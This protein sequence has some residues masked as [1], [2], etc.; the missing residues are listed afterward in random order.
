MHSGAMK[1]SYRLLL[2]L[3]VSLFLVRGEPAEGTFA[4]RSVP[5]NAPGASRLMIM[6]F[7]NAAL[8]TILDYLSDA[9]GLIIHKEADLHAIVELTNSTP[10]TCDQAVRL[11][12]AALEKSGGAVVRDGR[13]LHV[14]RLDSSKTS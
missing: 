10:V 14:V 12:N 7:H 11:L 2:C 6:D 1:A 3:S 8:D 9:A 13:I 4:G 5:A